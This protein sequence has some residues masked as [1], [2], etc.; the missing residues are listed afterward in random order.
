MLGT[1]LYALAFLEHTTRRLHITGVTTH[2]T[3]EWTTQQARNLA[4]DLGTRMESLRF[5]LRDRDGKYGQTFDAVFH[6][7]DLRIITSAPQAPRMSAHCERVI[8]PIRRELLDHILIMDER[9]ARQ[10]LKTYEDH[11]NRHRPHQARDQLPP[12]VRQHLA[13][14][15]DLDTHSVLRTCILGGLINEYRHAA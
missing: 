13:A 7:D 5:L 2:P 11:C 3:R 15:H 1:R 14:V 9:Y 8:G 12:E 4:F 10:V 6:A